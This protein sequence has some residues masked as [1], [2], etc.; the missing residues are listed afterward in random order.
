[1]ETG[2][3]GEETVNEGNGKVGEER[4]LVNRMWEWHGTGLR[5]VV[6]NWENAMKSHWQ[7]KGN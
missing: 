5:L 6:D 3:K 4:I 7:E 2:V 1:M